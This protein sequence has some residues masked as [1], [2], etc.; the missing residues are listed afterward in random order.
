MLVTHQ[1]RGFPLLPLRYTR[2]LS[3]SLVLLFVYVVS[4][5]LE[6]ARAPVAV[7][8]PAPEPLAISGSGIRAM[9]SSRS[10]G[11]K[12]SRGACTIG[13]CDDFNECTVNDTCIDGVCVGTPVSGNSCDAD[14]DRCTEGDACVDGVCTP[15]PP[16]TC[17]DQNPCTDDRC[18]PPSGCSFVRD[19][20]NPCTDADPC[21]ADVCIG[22]Q[23]VTQQPGFCAPTLVATFASSDV[24]K[25]ISS[26]AP[27][28]VTSRLDVTS[29]GPYLYD[30][31]VT[32]WLRHSRSSDLVVTLRSPAGTVVTLTSN[33]GAA[34][35]DVFNGTFWND[36]ADPGNEPPFPG[37]TFIGSQLATDGWYANGLVSTPLVPEEALGAFY[38][39][40]PTGAWVLTVADGNSYDGGSLDAWSLDIATLP[41]PPSDTYT[42]LASNDVPKMVPDGSSSTI[43]STL[44]VSGVG[45][46][47]GSLKLFTNIS[48][49]LAEDL[50]VT[51]RSP[52][53]TVVT[54]TTDNE[55]NG[56]P[57][58]FEGTWWDDKADPDSQVPL[59]VLPHVVT[60]FT[61][62]WTYSP[63]TPLV[64]EEALSA[65]RGEDPN[66]VWVLTVSDDYPS[67]KDG[68]LRAWGLGLMTVACAQV[69]PC[70][71]G[72]PCTADA[73]GPS[74]CDRSPVDGVP[75]DD[76][77]PCT[78]GD[79]CGAGVCTGTPNTTACDDRSACTSGDRCANSVC[80]S[81]P[82]D[83]N[84]RD[85]CTHDGCDPTI[86][87][88]H[89]QGLGCSFPTCDPKC[90]CEA[91]HPVTGYCEYLVYFTDR[92]LL[93]HADKATL[94]WSA[95][96][97]RICPVYDVARGLVNE[98]P[99]GA[100]ASESCLANGVGASRT[101][102]DPTMPPAGQSYWYLVRTQSN[103]GCNSLI[104]RYYGFEAQNGVL[105]VPEYT[106]VCE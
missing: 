8:G 68:V 9:G 57:N 58:A 53:G 104:S 61:Y 10:E 2:L 102:T 36:S 49:D 103:C 67:Y 91:C 35:D 15:G 32:T 38:G 80:A 88:V 70:D 37:D 56:R 83:C 41:A 92:T 55:G 60:D 84:D 62:G 24:P 73:C 7:Y 89:V 72:N 95:A 99:V 96:D 105:T 31:N 63:V 6:S 66:G 12:G 34:Y 50:D 21:T 27:S 59:P 30:V 20:R 47:L 28:T 90:G 78:S 17:D 101:A 13:P 3:S 43:T 33:N 79:T 98:L 54:I 40:N 25:P 52:R 42:Y 4:P 46:Q 81:T 45:D 82:V 77:N 87:C 106:P 14:G 85:A 93:F 44:L 11:T 97:S 23:C 5:C 39:E 51:L 16:A 71:D 94:E 18:D 69:S 74:G 26:A 65:F 86:G 76:G 22:G 29:G 19:D 1:P 75:C 100:G 64:V 48:H